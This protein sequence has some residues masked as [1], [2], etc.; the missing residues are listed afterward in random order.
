MILITPLFPL[1]DNLFRSIKSRDFRFEFIKYAIYYTLHVLGL[2]DSGKPTSCSPILFFFSLLLCNITITSVENV[3]CKIWNWETSPSYEISVSRAVDERRR[4]E[5]PGF[6][7]SAEN[8]IITIAIVFCP[9]KQRP[10]EGNVAFYGIKHG[11]EQRVLVMMQNY[12][13]RIPSA[14]AHQISIGFITLH[15]HILEE[16]RN[17]KCTK[18][19]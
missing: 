17:S 3:Q 4:S 19:Q 10:E 15:F 7:L 12:E 11:K 1:T 8:N 6:I 2:H 9:W 14:S 18:L 5:L 13:S 16:F